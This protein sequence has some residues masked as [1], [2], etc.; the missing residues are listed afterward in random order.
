M[1]FCEPTAMT[2]DNAK[3]TGVAIVQ[4]HAALENWHD[5]GLFTYVVAQGLM[6]KGD[7]DQTGS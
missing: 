3:R 6:G 7:V 2:T 1:H 4:P 5:H